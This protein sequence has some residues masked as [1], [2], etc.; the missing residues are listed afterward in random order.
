M[1]RNLVYLILFVF[2]LGC[3]KYEASLSSNSSAEFF[4]TELPLNIDTSVS[5][6]LTAASVTGGSTYYVCASGTSCG[7]GWKTGSDS[8][9][10]TKAKSRLTPFK[11]INYAA[12]QVVP[13]DLIVV[14]TGVYNT[15]APGSALSNVVIKKGGSSSTKLISIKSEK[16]W[17]A[18]I[19]AMGRHSG[20]F[21]N[22]DVSPVSYVRI[23]G[24]VIR[25]TSGFG[26]YSKDENSPYTRCSN[27]ELTNLK[28]YSVKHSGLN[29]ESTRSS[30]FANNVI[31][32]IGTSYKNP[33]GNLHHGIYLS[34]YTEDILLKNNVV[35][36]CN[37]GWPV[38][39]YDG[40]TPSKGPA[41]NHKVINNTLV[42]D[43]P[44]R[45]GGIVMRGSGHVVRNNLIYQRNTASNGYKGAIADSSSQTFSGTVVQNN[46]TNI[47]PLCANGCKSASIS[48]NLV[49]QSFSKEF[50]SNSGNNFRLIS[51]AKC[52]DKGTLSN[53]GLRNGAPKE[54][55]DSRARFTGK[56]P[57][58]GAF[59]K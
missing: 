26:V 28:I 30:M 42:A 2:T 41:K 53:Y 43:N 52:V 9:T 24:F 4:A 3:S 8:N 31:Y 55:N 38:H 5:Q 46:V 40:H 44:V 51:G 20:I 29:I 34:D 59:E 49:S 54:D 56:A 45:K 12:S 1:Q 11:T 19:D 10:K 36:G 48:G 14:G 32:S 22:C 6:A 58:A 25:N 18:I 35:Y 39:I 37:Y 21:I 13:G 57:E 33:S 50:V 16:K 47:S 15:I 7:S 17:G 27:L 23:D